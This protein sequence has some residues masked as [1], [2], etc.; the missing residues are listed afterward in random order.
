MRTISLNPHLN[1]IIHL[2]SDGEYHDGNAIGEK[3]NISRARVWRF[4]KKLEQYKVPIV[5]AKKKGYQLKSPLI[6]LDPKKL[7]S[8]LRHRSIKLKI[9]EKTTS[10]N[11][12]LKKFIKKNQTIAACF[13]ET[14]TAGKGR[15]HRQW[16]SPF[17]ENIYLSV[18]CPFQQDISELNGL[19]LVVALALCH[20][21]ESVIDLSGK[22]LKVKWPNDI[23]IDGCKLAGILI[24]IEAKSHG[25]SQV[26]IGMG[27]NVNMKIATKTNIDQAWISLTQVTQ[28][29]IDRNSLGAAMIDSLIDYLETFSCKKLSF[30]MSEWKKRDYLLNSNISVSFANKKMKGVS[31]GVNDQGHLKL[32]ELDGNILFLSSGETTLLK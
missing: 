19:S 28:Q 8:H 32:K 18:L 31:L 9:L 7:K 20:A 30:F 13:S 10:T 17:A 25:F 1:H 24:E 15:L 12:Y 3:L 29:Y 4:I 6:L 5:C 14:Q 23:L 22:K 21:I 27:I 16:H 26:V 2:L 11:D